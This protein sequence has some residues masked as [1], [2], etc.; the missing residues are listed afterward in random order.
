ML[1]SSAPPRQRL[2]SRPRRVHGFTLIELICVIVILGALSATA[3]PKFS[4]FQRDARLAVV[5]RTSA[6]ITGAARMAYY[7]CLLIAGCYVAFS[8]TKF[9]APS[10]VNG[11]T[12]FG[13]PTG[14]TR[15]NDFQG[16]KDWVTVSGFTVHEVNTAVAEFRLIG[17][18]TPTAC[19]VR[20]TE[21]ATLGTGP[22]I[23][24][25]TTGC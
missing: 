4:D 2:G 20:Y 13:W 1:G 23:V 19:L 10:G 15:P 6:E 25:V 5:A 12:Y 21:T 24:T 11:A 18:T 3:L 9:V 22:Q 14:Q 17:S 7:K 16:I 8:G